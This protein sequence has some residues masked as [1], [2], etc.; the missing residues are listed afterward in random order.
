VQVPDVIG[1]RPRVAR[2]LLEQAGLEVEQ[3]QVPVGDPNQANRVILQFPPAGSTVER[4]STVI[5]AIGVR[6]GDNG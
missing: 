1:R 6:L 2:G 5:I 3:R 4:G